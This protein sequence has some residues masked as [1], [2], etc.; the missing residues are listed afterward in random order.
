MNSLTAGFASGDITP[1]LGVAMSGYGSRT[2]PAESVN[3]PLYAQALVLAS[4]EQTAALVCMDN[5]GL[6]ADMVALVRERAAAQSGLAPERIMICGS[7]THWGPMTSG[8]RYMP[9]YL[10]ATISAEYNEKIISTIAGLVTQ[11]HQSRVAAVAGLGTGFADMITFNRRP[12][13]PDLKAEMHLVLDPVPAAA[14]AREGNRLA[15]KWRRGEHKGPRLSAPL[16]ELDGNR[17]GPADAE[18][19]LLR[20]DKSD[21][22]PLV[23]LANFACHAVCGS[24]DASF[25]AYSADWPGQARIAFADLIGAPMMYASGCSGDQVPRWRQSNSRERVGK[26]MGAEAAR[27][28]W[29]VDD[30]CGEVPLAVTSREVKLPPNQGVPPLAEAK[31][32]LA[33]KPNPDGPDAVWERAMVGLAEEIA[34]GDGVPAEIW[35]LRLGDLGLVGLPGEVLTEIGMQIKQ[36]SPFKYTMVVSLAN[37]SIGYLSTDEAIHAGGYEPEWSPVGLG[38]ERVLVET[39]LELLG[40]LH[41]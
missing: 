37:G 34:G 17:V 12:V 41:E 22:T 24:G 5:I 26:S 39:G 31:A 38:T 36:R 30:R 16:P 29:G 35:A 21:G 9:E 8:G 1:P 7:H 10:R 33:A 32:K 2:K 4:G 40:Q 20:I 19:G 23:G 18:V 3:D 6:N 15:R 28:W 13:K 25:Y 27:V 14:A 11:A